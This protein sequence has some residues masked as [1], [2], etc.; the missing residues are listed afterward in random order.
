[1]ND[2][3]LAL[4][5]PQIVARDMVVE[6]PLPGGTRVPMPGIPMKFSDAATPEFKTPPTLGRDTRSVLGELLG[7][8]A[9]KIDSLREARAIQ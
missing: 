3:A 6:V 1:V 2:F 5:D 7:Y 9:A 8:D 4:S